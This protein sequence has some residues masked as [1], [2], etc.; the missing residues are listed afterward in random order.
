MG[1]LSRRSSTTTTW[2]PSAKLFQFRPALELEVREPAEEL[3]VVE[4]EA[5][6]VGDTPA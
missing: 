2:Y 1:G 6:V 5:H 4:L 3:L